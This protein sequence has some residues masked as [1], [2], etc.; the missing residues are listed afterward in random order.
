[1]LN[2]TEYG[3]RYLQVLM[4]LQENPQAAQQHLKNP[5]VMNKF[6]KLVSAGIVQVK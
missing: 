6:Q 1:M 2:G 3:L 5:G 4:D